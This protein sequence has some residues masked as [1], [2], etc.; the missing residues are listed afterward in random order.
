MDVRSKVHLLNFCRKLTLNAVYFL[1]PLYFLK[2]GFKGYEIGLV[3]TLMAAA[4]L[5]VSFP[6]GWVNDRF[7]ISRVIR[8]ALLAQGA[9]LLVLGLSRGVPLTAAAYLLLGV[10]NNVLDVSTNSLYYKHRDDGDP[11][12]K[13]ARLAF[14]LNMG[15]AVGTAVGGVVAYLADFRILLFLF[16]GLMLPMPLLARGLGRE[17]FEAVSW[18]DYRR[19]MLQKKTVLFLI[20]LFVLA[21][22]WGAEGTVYSPFLKERFGLN[23]L[24]LSL[25]I[26]LTLLMTAAAS[27]SVGFLRFDDRRNALLFRGALLLSG[28]GLM[29]MTLRPLGLSF[30]GRLIHEAGDGL[31]GSTTTL[32]IARMFERRSVG[33]SAGLFLAI[34]TTGHI[35]GAQLFSGLGY[36]LGLA[37]PFLAAGA[38]LVAD[39]VFSGFVFRRVDY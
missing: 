11:N 28:V 18:A 24:Q 39:A 38:L 30:A 21:L 3:V 12:R 13:Y 8:T 2:L 20:M 16:A 32:Y 1:S 25:Y 31:L 5:V 19:N 26:S 15:I 6:T 35:I 22:H 10:A 37:V 23:I 34:I 29:L 4:P 17:R 14:F 33:G 36:G 27:L 9:A 7:S